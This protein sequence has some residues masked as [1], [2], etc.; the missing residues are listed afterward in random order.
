MLFVNKFEIKAVFKNDRLEFPHFFVKKESDIFFGVYCNHD[1]NYGLKGELI[2]SSTT[3]KG[4][5]KKAKLLEIGYMIGESDCENWHREL[6]RE[7]C[8]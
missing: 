7:C 5:A 6:C 1:R 3:F 8:W 4:A 2:A